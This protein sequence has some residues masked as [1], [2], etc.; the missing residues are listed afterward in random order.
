[1]GSSQRSIGSQGHL[2]VAGCPVVEVLVLVVVL[3]LD[4]LVLAP[5]AADA[6]VSPFGMAH[7]SQAQ[8]PPLPPI[9]LQDI[10]SGSAKEHVLSFGS[11][12]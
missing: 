9:S 11:A 10:L 7:V 6:H 2:L 3:V 12:K 8:V 1:M 4:V 5:A